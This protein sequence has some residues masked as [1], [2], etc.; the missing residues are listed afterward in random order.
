LEESSLSCGANRISFANNQINFEF[1]FRLLLT[2]TTS[3]SP[4]FCPPTPSFAKVFSA[5]RNEN[6]CKV[7][8][9]P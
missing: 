1:Y 5:A 3:S 2:P 9:G 8:P 4:I 6:V 7:F